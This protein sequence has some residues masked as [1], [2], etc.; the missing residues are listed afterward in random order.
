MEIFSLVVEEEKISKK[1]NE[2]WR[3]FT[4]KNEHEMESILSHALTYFLISYTD[5][6]FFFLLFSVLISNE[7]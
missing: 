7:T 5:Q 6:F 3:T 2:R 4:H 1:N